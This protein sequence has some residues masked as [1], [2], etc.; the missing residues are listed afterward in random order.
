MIS[1]WDDVSTGL[2]FNILRIFLPTA[3]T[4]EEHNKFGSSLWFDELWHWYLM[5]D[6]ANLSIGEKILFIFARFL[7]KLYIVYFKNFNIFI[8]YL[9]F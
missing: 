8:I 5:N 1:P 6:H 7:I 4:P 3:L 2:A 9:I